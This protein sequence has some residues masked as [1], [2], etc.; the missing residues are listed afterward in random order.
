M[1]LTKNGKPEYKYYKNAL[2]AE[3]KIRTPDPWD[4]DLIP[5]YHPDAVMASGKLK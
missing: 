3:R 4:F 2:H 1:S 5:K